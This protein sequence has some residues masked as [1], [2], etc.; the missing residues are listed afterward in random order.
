MTTKKKTAARAPGKPPE[1]IKLLHGI[2]KPALGIM[3][4]AA[5][6]EIALALQFGARKYGP[7]NWQDDKAAAIR[8]STYKHAMKRHFDLYLAGEDVAQDSQVHHLA[9]LAASC[10]ILIDALSTGRVNDKRVVNHAA[11]DRIYAAEKLIASWPESK[12]PEEV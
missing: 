1:K 2:T 9:H 3:P 6:V 5:D 10:V 11:I 12:F 7:D 8:V 4:P